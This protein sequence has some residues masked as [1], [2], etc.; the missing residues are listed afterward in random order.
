MYN[1]AE[2][3]EIIDSLEDA[4]K[5]LKA[6]RELASTLGYAKE[7]ALSLAETLKK[8]PIPTETQQTET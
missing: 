7:L 1:L 5:T 8:M 6:A 3:Q 4:Q 2:I